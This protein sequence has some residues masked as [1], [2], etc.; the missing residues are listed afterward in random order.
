MSVPIWPVEL[1]RPLRSAYAETLQ[2]NR[3]R[4]AAEHGVPRYAPRYSGVPA[5]VQLKLVLDPE[6]QGLLDRFYR[7]DLATGTLPFWMP[8]PRRD[9][10]PLLDTDGTP[11]LFE[12]DTP[13]LGERVM[14]CLW[15]DEP[16][17]KGPVR[18][19]SIDYSFA[20]YDLP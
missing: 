13:I 2:D 20:V 14:L 19:T 1:P 16:P 5:L 17:L 10:L 7:S 6:Q 8:D 4:R 15:G 3:R 9:G 18:G 11:L 12:D